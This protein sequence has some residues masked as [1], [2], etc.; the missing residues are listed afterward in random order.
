MS[1]AT[2][3]SEV[4]SSPMSR[5][6]R[7]SPRCIITHPSSINGADSN[8]D[9]SISAIPTSLEGVNCKP[10]EDDI[11]QR[12]SLNGALN[13]ESTF[14]R[15]QNYL[16]CNLVHGRQGSIHS[17]TS[18][19]ISQY[20]YH[21]P[22][23]KQHSR[24]SSLLDSPLSAN[25]WSFHSRQSSLEGISMVRKTSGRRIMTPSPL[26]RPPPP[27]YSTTAFGNSVMLKQMSPSSLDLGYHTMVNNNSH[28]SSNTSGECLQNTSSPLLNGKSTPSPTPKPPTTSRTNLAKSSYCRELPLLPTKRAVFP[29]LGSVNQN[30]CSGSSVVSNDNER[31]NLNH[32]NQTVLYKSLHRKNNPSEGSPFDKLP[33]ELIL[34]ILSNLCTLDICV[35]AKVCRKFYFLAW[36]PMLWNSITLDGNKLQ[37]LNADYAIKSLLNVLSRDP[38]SAM[39]NNHN[40]PLKQSSLVEKIFLSNCSTISDTGLLC[41]S[42]RCPELRQ[43]ELRNCKEVTNSGIQAI[44]TLCTSLDHLD[45]TGK[46]HF[47]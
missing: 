45:L 9:L 5:E 24:Q 31:V 2:G 11:L 16:D 43:L 22:T 40:I 20:M 44:A 12:T 14:P 41:I 3:I 10:L 15:R 7:L 17:S 33:N 8:S 26:A 42:D 39:A 6:F 21:N 23:K 1:T 35:C 13:S 47:G 28:Y 27:P 34:K 38:S 37:Y 4:Q 18:N 46:K 25:S 36:E 32:E 29:G 30:V 19:E